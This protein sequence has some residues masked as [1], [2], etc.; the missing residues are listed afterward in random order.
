[1]PLLQLV[2]RKLLPCL[3]AD[4]L[5]VRHWVENSQHQFDLFMQLQICVA[6]SNLHLI[7]SVVTT[8]HHSDGLTQCSEERV[9]LQPT[10]L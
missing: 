6:T 1:M 8:Y 9:A 10:E 4:C 7:P 2:K 5:L 3:V